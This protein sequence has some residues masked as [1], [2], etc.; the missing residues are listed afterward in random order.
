MNVLIIYFSQTGNTEK[1]AKV[2]QKSILNNDN[3]CEIEKIKDVDI[4]IIHNFDLIGF[5]TPT[6]FYREP[7]N[8]K[9]FINTLDKNKKEKYCFLFSTH[10]SLIGNTFYYMNKELNKKGFRVIATYDTYANSSIQFYPQPMHTA[11]HPDE[12]ELKS[13]EDFGNNVCN[14]LNKFL[15]GEQ[16]LIPKFTLREDTWWA[17]ESKNITT[18]LLRKV[19][20]KFVINK[21]KC[22]KCLS[23]QRGCPVD[24]IDIEKDPPEIQKGGCIFCWYCEKLCPE[25]AI[26]ADW[27]FI[28]KVN[29]PNLK[30]YITEL[31]LAENEGQFRPYI[32]YENIF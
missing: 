18:E 8:V 6:F 1:I 13:A 17:K 30:K 19:S 9:K 3:N 22:T 15:N 24:A 23:C 10:G 26:E 4:S 20:P 7:Q 12:I 28:R 31:K 2:I 27:T 29:K 14:T 25:G 32:D 21:D 5:G 16:N 11:G